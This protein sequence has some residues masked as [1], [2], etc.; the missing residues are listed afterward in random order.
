MVTKLPISKHYH[1]TVPNPTIINDYDMVSMPLLDVT[2]TSQSI[3]THN[4]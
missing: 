4:V 3:L 1:G 2:W